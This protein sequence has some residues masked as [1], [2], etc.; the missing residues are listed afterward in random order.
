[1]ARG[2]LRVY[3][4]AA[5]G[6][7]KTVKMLEEGRRRQERGTDVVV[8]L[9]ETHGRPYIEALLD[10]LESVELGAVLD[11]KPEV[12]LIDEL[13]H[14]ERWQDVEVLLDA[15]ITVLTTLN[16]QHLESLT[17]VAEQITGVRPQETVPDDV[18]R[19]ADQVELVDMTAEALR[20][21]VAHG[22]VY[23]PDQVD[24]ALSNYFR[25]GN[26]T[27]L[28]ELALLWLA[29][30]V[31]EQLDRNRAEHHIDTTWE[32]RERVAVALNG[33]GEGETLIRRGARIAARSKGADLMAVHVARNDG[34]AGANPAHL[35][36]QRVL[37][38]SLG[39]SYHQVLGA[40][41]PTA[42]V[43]FACGVNATQLVLGASRRGR[44]AR[45][46]SPGVGATTAAV[47]GSID[48]HL[49]THEAVNRGRVR[50]A[51]G[52]GLTR[53]RRAIGLAAAVVGLPALTLGL[54]LVRGELTFPSDVLLFVAAVVAVALIGGLYPAL[55]AAV[56]GFLLL[57]Y[58]FTPPL[59][60]FAIDRVED[61]VALVV[62][63][64]VG[65]AVSIVVELAARR[66][67]EASSARVEAET[68]STVAG[69]VLRGEDPLTALLEQLRET[70]ALSSVTLL[71]RRTDNPA[72]W[73]IAAT[74]GGRPAGSPGDGDAVVPIGDEL[75]LVLSGQL[76][77]AADRRVVEAFAAQSAVALRQQRLV[78]Q[79]A[80]AD[81]IGAADRLRSA[82][83]SAVSHDLRTPLA[84]AKAAVS[85][86]RSPDV[87]FD[88]EDRAE[89]LATAD[90]SLDRLIGLVE[91]LLDMSR[92]QAGVLG[93]HAQLISVADAIPRVIDD[94]GAGEVAV[95]V[96]DD[97]SDVSADPALLERILV[98]VLANAVRY[99]PPGRPPMIIV[100][101][102]GD[103]VEVR[104]ID[105]G[106]GI[107][108]E[109]RE[110]V[111]QP[112]QRL[113]DRN[114]G[115]GVGL[116]LALSRGLAEAMGGTLQPETTPGGG[117]TMVLRLRT[118]GAARS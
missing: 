103:E 41:I 22:D 114:G 48:V 17:D 11:R 98:N 71:E 85:S 96:P 109:A 118:A 60:N 34:L 59:H 35:A 108:D 19:R 58:Y 14:R 76:L 113:G 112:F 25:V 92:L 90:E 63:L 55:A 56:G 74:V 38:E 8:G 10:G 42:L 51:P 18:V 12:A 46:F 110:L 13:A 57:N 24:A 21:R 99:S 27:A 84:S 36:R 50:L 44:I 52:R 64:V 30:R 106:P 94:V 69:S 5:P 80:T 100:S 15:G 70:F 116:G 111:F 9:V 16:V 62:F 54:S 93:V 65:T 68:L 32:A 89:L 40:D 97:L 49:V 105:H 33:G 77:A 4:G 79:A 7:G 66:T 102:L 87:V 107:P 28:R 61:V 43:D 67:A 2:Q 81:R 29:D 91:N 117:L 86:L 39:G 6:V 83:L 82:L 101:E 104:V 75:T 53:R 23:G 73:W 78:A 31:D 20:Q 45:L 95:R 47:A 1:M 26:L 37:V 3:L 115:T 88:A 72:G